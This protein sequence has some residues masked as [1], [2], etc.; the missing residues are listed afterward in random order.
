MIIQILEPED[1]PQEACEILGK[2][3]KVVLGE[4]DDSCRQQVEVIFTRLSRRIDAS[5]HAD[6][7]SLR[8]L[9]SPTT[10]LDHI[11]LSHFAAAGVRVISLRGETEFLDTI[12]ATAEHTIGLALGLLRD[13]PRATAAVRGGR[14]DRTRHK[15]RELFGKKVF[16]L[17]YGRIGRLVHPLFEAFGCRVFAN[18]IVE[19][20][21]PDALACAFPDVLGEVDIL[22]IHLP[23]NDETFRFVDDAMLSRLPA[24]AFVINTSRGS[25]IDQEALLVRLEEGR[26][27][28]A[29]LDVLDGEPNP[30]SGDLVARIAALSSRLVV[31]PHIG[32]Y[33]WESLEAV[34]VFVARRLQEALHAS[35]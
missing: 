4:I 23:L 12:H 22:S 32:G 5:F 9:V 13:L 6:Y 24:H 25:V 7:P 3:G 35:R 33:T 16:L 34:E 18:D 26:L 11:D 30:L 21:V 1:F 31:T 19:G 2:M 17:G 15:G 10:G 27:V 8:A 14:W 20:R 28:G 29:A